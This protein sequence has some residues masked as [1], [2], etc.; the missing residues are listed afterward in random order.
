VAEVVSP[1]TL[2]DDRL[3]ERLR[4]VEASVPLYRAVD[5]DD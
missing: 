1:S 5:G 2:D 3:L 4:Y